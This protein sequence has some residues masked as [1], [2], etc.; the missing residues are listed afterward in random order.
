MQE[1]KRPLESRETDARNHNSDRLNE[2][3]E[4]MDWV[5]LMARIGPISLHRSFAPMTAIDATRGIGTMITETAFDI[6]S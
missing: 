5:A 4:N 2:K 1:D 3:I 6:Q